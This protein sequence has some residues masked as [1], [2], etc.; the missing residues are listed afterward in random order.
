MDSGLAFSE[1]PEEFVDLGL[2]FS[3]SPGGFVDSG[4][5]LDFI[6]FSMQ[7]LRL[8]NLS[9]S[10]VFKPIDEAGLGLA[11]AVA[12]GGAV[13]GFKYFLNSDLWKKYTTTQ[14][15]NIT[16]GSNTAMNHGSLA[17][18]NNDSAVYLARCK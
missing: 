6:I 8:I 4:L 12:G 13:V 11:T 16:A 2:A 9:L 5:A 17:K 15:I 1:S 14:I 7:V 10:Q 3:E 18:V